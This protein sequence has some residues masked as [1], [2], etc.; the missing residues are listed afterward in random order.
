MKALPDKNYI[1]WLMILLAVFAV[2]VINRIGFHVP[3]FNEEA[4]QFLLPPSPFN[5]ED[6]IFQ[7]STAADFKRESIKEPRYRSENPL[8]FRVLFGK[9]AAN[10]MLGVVDESEGMA[11]G[12][13]VME[14]ICNTCK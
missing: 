12:Y 13:D 7:P 10:P 6:S 2:I 1:L 3:A 11:G 14:C 9:E 5:Q 4:I 8:Y